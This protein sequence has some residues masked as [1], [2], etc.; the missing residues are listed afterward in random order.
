[1]SEARSTSISWPQSHHLSCTIKICELMKCLNEL[2]DSRQGKY[3][4]DTSQALI[5]DGV[6]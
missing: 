3:S 2:S 1:M 6:I 4:S 5:A